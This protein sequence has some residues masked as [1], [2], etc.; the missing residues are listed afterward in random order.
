MSTI[1]GTA[2]RAQ[3]SASC[4]EH[5]CDRQARHSA[6]PPVR[7][8]DVWERP[9]MCCLRAMQKVVLGL[10]ALFASLPLSAQDAAAGRF[11]GTWEA[12][13]KD[14]VICTIRVKAGDPMSGETANCNIQVDGNGDLEESEGSAAGGEIGRA[15][16][17]ER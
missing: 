10:L 2:R 16:C 8:L 15:S 7:Q 6:R 14:K 9:A 3:R 1:L 13:F 4:G 17:R 11:A 12:K 5:T